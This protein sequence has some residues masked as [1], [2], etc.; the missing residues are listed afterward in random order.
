MEKSEGILSILILVMSAISLVI[1]GTWA[2]VTQ[3]YFLDTT[4]VE[5]EQTPFGTNAVAE[6]EYGN[7]WAFEQ[8]RAEI[9]DHYV[10][11]M[12]NVRN[13]NLYDDIIEFAIKR[14]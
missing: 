8:G 3:M 14:N 1:Y 4:V 5:I 7:L 12:D 10:L 6:D 2:C 11:V 13:D 9:G